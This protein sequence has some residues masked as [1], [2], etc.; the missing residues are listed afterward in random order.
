ML[1]GWREQD[2]HDVIDYLS[3]FHLQVMS[4]RDGSGVPTSGNNLVIVGIDSNGLLHI[5]IYD[6]A[7]NRIT[8][9][10]ETKLPAAQNAAI[11]TLK[12]QLPGLLPSHVLTDAEKAQV[13]GD[14]TSIVGQTNLIS[15]HQLSFLSHFRNLCRIHEAFVVIRAC[16]LPA[17]VLLELFW[18]SGGLEESDVGPLQAALRAKYNEADWLALIKSI[19]DTMRVK[20]RDALVAYILQ[21]LGDHEET[22]HINT[23]DKLFEL[24]L[25]DVAMEPCMVTSRIRVAL[26]SVQLFIERCVRNLEPDVSPADI[27]ANQ[28]RWMKRYRVWQ[29]NREVFLWPEN[30]LDPELRD[31]QSPFFKEAMSELLQSDITDDAAQSAFLTYLK[32]LDEVA[33]LEPCGLHFLPADKEVPVEKAYVIA[34]TSGAHRKYYFRRREG[35]TWT[36]WEELK[37]DI[38]DVPVTPFVWS[39]RLLPNERRP[40]ETKNRSL[41]SDRLLVFWLKILKETPIDPSGLPDPPSPTKTD[42]L[43]NLNYQ[44]I[45][46]EAKHSVIREPWNTLVKASAV[47][48]WSEYY[49]GKWQSPKTS[50]LLRPTVIAEFAGSTS[51]DTN[52]Y[53]LER[54]HSDARLYGGMFDGLPHDTVLV[55]IGNTLIDYGKPMCGFLLYNTT[56]V[57]IRAQDISAPDYIQV[58]P[59]R[60]FDSTDYKGAHLLKL[61][62]FEASSSTSSP[63]KWLLWSPMTFHITQPQVNFSDQ[64]SCWNAPFFF[65]DTRNVFYVTTRVFYMHVPDYQGYGITHRTAGT[66]ESVE[67]AP[68]ILKGGAKTLVSIEETNCFREPHVGRKNDE[69]FTV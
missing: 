24:L 49:N 11:A 30:W 18:L 16:E 1:T 68:C 9:T 38:E 21:Q 26:S 69:D 61:L 51:N 41:W 27:D 59:E 10:D 29:A 50:D 22:K 42:P 34:R 67:I 58:G 64:A 5:R 39:D 55:D 19:N 46:R 3:A 48:C 37:L 20:Q 25:M 60:R 56:S 31:D 65:S 66:Q 14:A 45:Q 2:L 43:S 52:V 13:I 44:D 53:S 4:W 33:K 23:P 17:R 12:Q 6:D 63:P 47:L 28:W 57:P 54:W 7:G 62:Y 40:K 32:K 15:Q 35:N 36:P 8:D